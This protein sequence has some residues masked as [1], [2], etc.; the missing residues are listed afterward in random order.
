MLETSGLVKIFYNLSTD[1]GMSITFKTEQSMQFNLY[2]LQ[3]G[4]HF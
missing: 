3:F 2:F 1:T 4:E